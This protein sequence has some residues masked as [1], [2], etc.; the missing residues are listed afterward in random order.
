[1]E[2]SGLYIGWGVLATII[3]FVIA[4]FI[5]G[6]ELGKTR[7]GKALMSVLIPAVGAAVAGS[8]VAQQAYFDAA[9][10]ACANCDFDDDDSGSTDGDGPADPDGGIRW[11]DLIDKETTA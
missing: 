11:E 5:L 1:M 6:Y 2:S 3:L 10:D 8:V 9:C 7:G 4:I